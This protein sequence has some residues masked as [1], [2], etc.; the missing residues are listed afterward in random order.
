L[1]PPVPSRPASSRRATLQPTGEVRLRIIDGPGAGT[2]YALAGPV[3]RLGRGEE[4]DI[5]LPDTNCSRNHAEVVRDRSGRFLV[6]DL[7]SRN[8]VFVNRRKVPQAG[9]SPG[10][11]ILIGGTLLEFISLGGDPT[12]VAPSGGWIKVALVAAGIAGLLFLIVRIAGEG[13]L[14]GRAAR[15][16]AHEDVSLSNLLA[17]PTPN[18]VAVRR[19][20]STKPSQAAPAGA[21]DASGS[22]AS[23]PA[24]RVSE[25][26]QNG[27]LA[28]ASDKLV[29]ARADFTAALHLDPGCARCRSR[30]EKCENEIRSKIDAHFRSGQK[31]FDTEL[32]QQALQE[33]EEVK[34][35]DPD[36]NSVNYANAQVRINEVKRKMTAEGG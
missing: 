14:A 36:T 18:G 34:L 6:R 17:N 27:D 23:L 26:M 10:D 29:D 5:V 16:D 20:D 12:P 1:S 3:V 25:L 7:G 24:G 31:Y 35:L 13:R 28:Y 30:L 32:Y 2:E 22:V 8:G 4:N 15:A 19:N 21:P 33:Y 9:L 11:K